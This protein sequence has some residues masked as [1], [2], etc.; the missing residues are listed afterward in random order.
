LDRDQA[1]EGA[2]L[3]IGGD[4]MKTNLPLIGDPAIDNLG[5][6]K[7]HRVGAALVMSEQIDAQFLADNPQC[8]AFVRPA[9]PDEVPMAKGQPG[10]VWLVVVRRGQPAV[11]FIHVTTRWTPEQLLRNEDYMA[12]LWATYRKKMGQISSGNV[13][14]GLPLKLPSRVYISNGQVSVITC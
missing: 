3:N 2:S 1:D 6:E 10:E 9:F 14:E 12:V 5:P 8:Q 4:V 11:T 13:A 7:W